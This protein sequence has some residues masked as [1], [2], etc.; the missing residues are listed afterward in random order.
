MIALLEGIEQTS[1]GVIGTAQT[2]VRRME[3]QLN[4]MLVR[5][6]QKNGE[7][8]SGLCS[9][10]GKMGGAV[11]D[12]AGAVIEKAAVPITKSVVETAGKLTETVAKSTLDV[13]ESITKTSADTAKK[14]LDSAQEAQSSFMTQTSN[15][16][17]SLKKT[18]T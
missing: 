15:L 16:V 10:I 13:A 9:L 7:T 3:G 1:T 4:S 2:L 18:T 8:S 5:D 12:T 14:M 6:D 17:D 11:V